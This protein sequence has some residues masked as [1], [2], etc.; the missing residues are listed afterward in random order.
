MGPG[1]KPR[2]D[3]ECLASALVLT[4]IDEV[5]DDAWVGQCRGVAEV[6]E[7]I[8]RDLAQDAAHDLAGAGLFLL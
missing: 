7:F 2:D 4:V 1:I 3:T 8:L 5:V 6:G